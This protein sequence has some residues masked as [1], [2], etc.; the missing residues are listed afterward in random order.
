MTLESRD[1]FFLEELRGALGTSNSSSGSSI[2]D[3]DIL[4]GC[5]VEGYEIGKLLGVGSAGVVFEARRADGADGAVKVMPNSADEASLSLFKRE[6]GI[7]QTL[8]HPSVLKTWHACEIEQ[9]RFVFMERVRGFTLRRMVKEPLKAD[10]FLPL[11]RPIAEALQSAHAEGIVH[12]DMKPENVMVSRDGEV[13]ILDFGLA[14][15][16]KGESVTMTGQIKGTIAYMAPEQAMDS[17]KVGP[18][19]DQF[20]FGLMCFEA[21]TGVIPYDMS[22]K[23]PVVNL[24]SRLQGKA[25]SLRSIDASFSEET[26]AVLAKMLAPDPT[27][28]YS[29]VQLAFAS[30]AQSLR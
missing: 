27:E 10:R 8:T 24:M 18:A 5:Q 14:R 16:T 25:K 22:S 1:R 4:E 9:A 26:E 15:L 6:V 28:R 2:A 12:R 7:G 21:L 30:L 13:K 23:N 17:K 20:A 19:C 11:F 3:D 29:S